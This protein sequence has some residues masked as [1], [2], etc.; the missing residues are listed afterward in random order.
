VAVVE[1]STRPV[2]SRS[3]SAK[4]S[5][6]PPSPSGEAPKKFRLAF[7]MKSWPAE[8]SKSPP[9][10]ASPSSAPPLPRASPSTWAP[11]VMLPPAFRETK[12]PSP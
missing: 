3:R 8:A 10:P 1:T 7:R 5:T 6:V 9:V 12:P 11:T 4:M 2:A